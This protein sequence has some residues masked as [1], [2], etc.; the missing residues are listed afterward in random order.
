MNFLVMYPGTSLALSGAGLVLLAILS[1]APRQRRVALALLVLAPISPLLVVRCLAV[2]TTE[3]I[4]W[5]TAPY[6]LGPWAARTL[7][8]GGRK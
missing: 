4:D 6:P 1:L 3:L 8:S 2:W 7:V 5:I